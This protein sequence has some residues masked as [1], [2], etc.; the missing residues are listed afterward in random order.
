MRILIQGPGLG[1]RGAG[2]QPIFRSIGEPGRNGIAFDVDSDAIEFGGS[3]HPVVKGLVLPKRSSRAAKDAIG[4]PRGYTF[5]SICDAPYGNSGSDQ[6]VYVVGHDY[7]GLQ[8]VM[9]QDTFASIYSV[10]HAAG[11]AGIF[12]PEW[13]FRGLVQDGVQNFEPSSA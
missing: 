10:N 11:D 3:A 13:A 9:S 6:Q 8:S 4:V 12:E 7:E 5:Q 1:P 2:P